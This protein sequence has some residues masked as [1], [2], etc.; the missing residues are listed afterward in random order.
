MI[1][2]LFVWLHLFWF[3]VSLIITILII[4][5]HTNK[6]LTSI[7]QYIQLN[8]Y[9]GVFMIIWDSTTWDVVIIIGIM[10]RDMA[11]EIVLKRYIL[12]SFEDVWV[13]IDLKKI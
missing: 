13:V 12:E 1:T 9:F 2:L 5:N 3:I 10:G 11:E 8:I 6:T 4:I 7:K